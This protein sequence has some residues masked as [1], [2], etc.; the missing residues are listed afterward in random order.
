[1]NQTG[2]GIILSLCVLSA[3]CIWNCSE[4]GNEPEPKPELPVAVKIS[5]DKTVLKAN[6]TD[7]VVFTVT[8]NDAKVVTDAF[9][10]RKKETNETDTVN[11]SNFATR[12]AGTYIFYASYKGNTSDEISI[13]ATAVVVLLKADRDTIKA[14]DRDVVQFTVTADEQN[15]T[16]SAVVT[17]AGEQETVLDGVSFSA[18]EPSIYTFYAI[19]DG[20]KSNEIRI[21]ATEVQYLLTVDRTSVIADAS[22]EA[23]FTVTVDGKDVT[24]AAAIYQKY[25]ET[26]TALEAPVF[27][28]ENSGTY[29]FHAVYEGKKTNEVVVNA[30]YVDRQFFMQHVVMDFT[31][32]I[33]PNCPRVEATVREVQDKLPGQVHRIALHMGGKHCDSGLSGVMGPVANNLSTDDYFPSVKVN[34][35]YDEYLSAT[36]MPSR[37]SRAIDNSKRDR[38]GVSETGIAIE[39]SVNGTDIDFTVRIKSIKTDVYSFFAFIVEDGITYSQ[40]IP[41]L[42]S[43][44][45]FATVRN[46]VHNDIATYSLDSDPLQGVSLGPVLKGKETVKNFTIHAREG[47]KRVVNLSKCRII[48]YTIRPN[49]VIDNVVNCPIYGSVRYRYA[50]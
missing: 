48:G 17:L 21:Q 20:A 42:A 26:E 33:C 10:I 19:Y 37:I 5:A 39:S 49:G 27:F 34:L 16:S 28:T 23:T 12:E 13:E 11:G 1:M 6:G 43:E 22:E 4:G 50:E 15:V 32:T 25:D 8:A 44:A 35:K 41:D 45:G 3:V 40:Q 2:K 46:Y 36:T 18:K 9:I 38:G 30:E 31:S 7:S 14:N 29:T 47:T 24:P